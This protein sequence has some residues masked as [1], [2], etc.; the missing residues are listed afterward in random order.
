LSAPSPEEIRR[1]V[2]H[3]CH[4]QVL[5]GARRR[6][7]LL[8]HIVEGALAGTPATESS[9]AIAI[10]GKDP[11]LFNPAVD[12]IA[13]VETRKVRERLKKFYDSEEGQNAPVRI[14][15]SKYTAETQ[16]IKRDPSKPLK[17]P[18]PEL[19]RRVEDIY[20]TR[21]IPE[22][23]LQLPAALVQWLCG[24]GQGMPRLF[25]AK[26]YWFDR[27]R[28]YSER[29][30]VKL[31]HQYNLIRRNDYS[32]SDDY[33]PSF[34]PRFE[35]DNYV[36]MDSDGWI[37]IP[38]W[39]RSETHLNHSSRIFIWRPDYPNVPGYIVAA[40]ERFWNDPPRIEPNLNIDDD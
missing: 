15:I 4:S 12:A 5:D 11:T 33:D 21:L 7:D 8:R 39:M 37:Q 19:H 26:D 31:I 32:E 17:V 40:S 22:G 35:D 2:E 29:S 16:Y 1:Q 34:S 13:R 18:A 36:Y 27:M 30:A 20:I 25:L 6:R 24:G 14:T 9:I 38:D 23:W 10:Y 3:I 28:I